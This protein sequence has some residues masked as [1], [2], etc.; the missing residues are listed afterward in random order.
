MAGAICFC[1]FSAVSQAE[2]FKT[3]LPLSHLLEQNMNY[4]SIHTF[5]GKIQ[6]Y[7]R[8]LKKGFCKHS[9]YIKLYFYLRINLCV[10]F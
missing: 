8:F 3:Y 1:V 2:Q 10:Q 5:T 9:L 6:F 4:H 7:Q